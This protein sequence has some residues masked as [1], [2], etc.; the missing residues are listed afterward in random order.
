M[1]GKVTV[2]REGFSF[3]FRKEVSSVIECARKI[4]EIAEDNRREKTEEQEKKRHEN[5]REVIVGGGITEYF[6]IDILD[7]RKE[8]YSTLNPQLQCS[9]VSISWPHTLSSRLLYLS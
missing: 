9:T 1:S 3:T 8:E 4:T 7:E 2:E 5:I 6:V